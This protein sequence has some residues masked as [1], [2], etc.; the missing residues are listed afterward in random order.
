MAISRA[1][2]FTANN[3]KQEYFSDFFDSFI[4][5][6]FNKDLVLVKN[7]DAVKQSLKNL[8]KTSLTER[9][10]QPNIGGNVLNSMFELISTVSLGS[11]QFNIE[12]TI[13]FNEPR[14]KLISLSVTETVD[15]NA[16]QIDI[17][18]NLINNPTPISL[19]FLLSK[20]R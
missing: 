5:T 15:T 18:F 13:K 16:V 9:L 20:A 12:N 8:I 10:Y 7:E 3:K 14:V 6:P 17:V 1:D 4:A 19:N 11:L 2:T